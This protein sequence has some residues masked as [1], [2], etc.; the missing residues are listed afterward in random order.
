MTLGKGII[1]P[2]ITGEGKWIGSGALLSQQRGGEGA[3]RG[4]GQVCD[5]DPLMCNVSCVTSGVRSRVR[6]QARDETG[7]EALTFTQKL[8]N[9]VTR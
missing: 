6:R 1:N 5:F 8:S 4:S 9:N 3:W 7:Q 2:L